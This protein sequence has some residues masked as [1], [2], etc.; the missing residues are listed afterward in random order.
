MPVT[1]TDEDGDEIEFDSD[2]EAQ[3]WAAQNGYELEA[4]GPYGEDDDLG[5]D[6]P[7]ENLRAEMHELIAQHQAPYYGVP[8]PEPSDEEINERVN[9][10]FTEFSARPDVPTLTRKQADRMYDAIGEG[11]EDV[12]QAYWMSNPPDMTN[13]DQR[14]EW[15]ADRFRDEKAYGAE[16]NG[17]AEPEL[18]SREDAVNYVRSLHPEWEEAGL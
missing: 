13:R 4:E 16:Q 8:E 3:A 11:A 18:E 5:P 7:I 2:E 17:T 14:V 12:Q 6:D 9:E 1:Y 15:M 10:I